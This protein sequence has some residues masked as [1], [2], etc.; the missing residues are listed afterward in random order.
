MFDAELTSSVIRLIRSFRD[1]KVAV[2]GDI[3]LDEYIHGTVSRISP[4]APVPI[5]EADPD[6]RSYVL[7]G[8]ANVARNLAAL[9]AN[10]ELV[11]VVGDDREATVVRRLLSESGIGA[12]DAAIPRTHCHPSLQ[13]GVHHRPAERVLHSR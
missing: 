9:G 13:W 4:E 5:L 1:T 12:G 6:R 8:A 3:M 11:G 2:L 7:G 10:V